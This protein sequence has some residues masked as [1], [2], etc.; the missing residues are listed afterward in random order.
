MRSRAR[1]ASFDP[2]ASGAIHHHAPAD[3]RDQCADRRDDPEHVEPAAITALFPV[4]AYRHDVITWR[5]GTR[6]CPPTA[7]LRPTIR[8]TPR[9][10]TSISRSRCCAAAART[11]TRLPITIARSRLRSGQFSLEDQ[12]IQL[13]S[14][15][16]LAYWTVV[17]ARENLRVQEKALELAD[18][19]LETLQARIGIRRDFVARN[20]PAARRTTP[21]RRL[22]SRRRATASSRPRTHCAARWAPTR[23]ASTAE[24]PIVLT[25]E[26]APPTS[27]ESL[28]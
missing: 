9:T 27:T 3:D 24:I 26:V 17:E 8:A 1:L 2:Q 23:T 18:T 11:I 20:L 28:R 13:I 21:P 6:S 10:S 4:A 5:S 22:R 15:A 14:Q 25:E 19:A 12:V 16:E 7:P